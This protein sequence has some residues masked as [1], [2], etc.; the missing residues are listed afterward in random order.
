M[1]HQDTL[2]TKNLNNEDKNMKW[3][4]LYKESEN[5]EVNPE[6]E[7]EAMA[8]LAK[9]ERGTPTDEE[10]YKTPCF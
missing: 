5:E 6:A 8:V 9:M 2:E 1:V 4:R 7:D 3:Y 10:F